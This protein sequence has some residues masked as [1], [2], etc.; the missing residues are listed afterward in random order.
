MSGSTQPLDPATA[1]PG[2]ALVRSA[3]FLLLSQGASTA[4]AVV[5]GG[6]LGRALGPT[7]FGLYFFIHSIAAFAFVVAEWG[8]YQYV[9]R[10]LSHD[11]GR[12]PELLGAAVAVRAGAAALLGSLTSLSIL[13]AGYGAR[14]SWLAALM[15]A[16]L[17]PLFLAQAHFVIFRSRERMELEAIVTVVD[18]SLT[19]V[20]ALLAL[21]VGSGIP[22]VLLAQGTAGLGALGLAAFL[23]SRLGVRPRVPRFGL[24]KELIGGG[25]SMALLSAE[26]SAQNYVD[27]VVL[28]KLAPPSV[29]GWFGAARNIAGTLIAPAIVL[30]V[31]CYP[32]LSRA[33]ADAP[34][35]REEL[36]AGLR[37]TFALGVLVMVGTLLFAPGVVAL[38]YGASG[39]AQSGTILKLLAPVVFLYFVDNLLTAAAIASGRPRP[40]AIAKVVNI[41]V[42]ASLAVALVP[43][44]ESRFGNGALG[45]VTATGLGEFIMMGTALRVLPR[46]ALDPRLLLDLGRALLAGAGS[47]ALL[48]AM[49]HLPL[50]AG[51]VGCTACFAALALALRMVSLDEIR[52]LVIHR[53]A[54]DVAGSGRPA[55]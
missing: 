51:I 18:K 21:A 9:V 39:F 25:A 42:I 48:R 32:R 44:F 16:A 17:L 26:T 55:A 27:P 40:M 45:M 8:Q 33:A 30:E 46:G 43:L 1:P 34:R 2:R 3:S 31:S 49:V 52:T 4:L 19:V 20:L 10:E 53:G 38:V 54:A 47:L 36:R 12:G 29:L 15:V 35:F 11:P 37:L 24:A 6:A 41:I 23:T 22:G 28:S 50:F 14:R 5:L 13:L 7:D